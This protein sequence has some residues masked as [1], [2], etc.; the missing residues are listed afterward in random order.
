[1]IGLLKGGPRMKRLV[2]QYA[3]IWSCWL[4]STNS[5]AS[6]YRA[7]MEAMMAVCEK[8]GRDPATLQKAVTPRICPTELR[9]SID[10]NPICGSINE[11][12]DDIRRFE[13]MGVNHLPVWLWPNSQAS[14]EAFAP[15]LEALQ[16]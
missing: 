15:V 16:S 3:D 13:D 4:A 2:A 9:P 11:M 5:H 14:V 10:N 12:A 1:M 6:A 7:P 8:Y